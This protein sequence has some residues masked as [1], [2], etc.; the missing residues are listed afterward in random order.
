M[1]R[2]AMATAQTTILMKQQ[3]APRVP[4]F[5]ESSLL[6]LDWQRL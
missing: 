2:K 4:F 1:D 3:K 6:E 5:I